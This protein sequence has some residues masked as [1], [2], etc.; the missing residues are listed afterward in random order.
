MSEDGT[1]SVKA[2]PAV[3]RDDQARGVSIQNAVRRCRTGNAQVRLQVALRGELG[4]GCIE[5]GSA[6]AGV[7]E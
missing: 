1:I 5:L 2:P 4:K 3:A 7:S 6:E